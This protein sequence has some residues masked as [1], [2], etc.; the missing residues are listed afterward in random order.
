MLRI[1]QNTNLRDKYTKLTKYIFNFA[2]KVSKALVGPT[3]SGKEFYSFGAA[4][5]LNGSINLSPSVCLD[6]KLA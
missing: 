2:L 6:W 1:L 5:K 3:S 4:L